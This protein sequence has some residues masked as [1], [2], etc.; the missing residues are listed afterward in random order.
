MNKKTSLLELSHFPVMMN[1][2]IKISSPHKGGVYIDCTFGGG[3]YSRQLLKFPNTVIKGLDCDINVT[4]IGDGA[5]TN[6]ELSYLNGITSFAVGINDAQI[7]TNK[8]LVDNVTTL[9]DNIDA[10]KQVKFQVNGI[11]TGQTREWSFQDSND[12]S[13]YKWIWLIEVDGY[14]NK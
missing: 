6:T 5:V 1:E 12:T 11:S 8:T 2:V 13:E 7:L 10:T 14:I 3:N 4:K 9:Q